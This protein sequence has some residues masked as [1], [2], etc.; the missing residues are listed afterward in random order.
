MNGGMKE[1]ASI[2]WMWCLL[3]FHQVQAFLRID[4]L[5]RDFDLTLGTRGVAK[6]DL[7]LTSPNRQV[8]R[9]RSPLTRRLKPP[10]LRVTGLSKLLMIYNTPHVLVATVGSVATDTVDQ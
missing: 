2:I 7:V 5:G 10:L 1:E 4:K 6:S 9:H 3:S 8:R